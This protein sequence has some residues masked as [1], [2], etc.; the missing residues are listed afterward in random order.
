MND[1]P[2][3]PIMRWLT[4]AARL[5]VGAVFVVSGCTKM[6]DLW[7]F[8]F[9]IADYLAVWHMDV[10]Q[11]LVLTGAALL[12]LA[13]FTSGTALMLGCYRRLSLLVV[14]AIMGVMLPLTVY[15]AIAS[16]VADCGCFGD[17]LVISNT[18]TLLKNVVI[19]GML[20]IL[21]I[22]NARVRPF[23]NPSLQWISASVSMIY[24]IVVGITGYTIQPLVDFR[25]Y[26][27]GTVLANDDYYDTTGDMV[28]IYE[29]DGARKE[30]TADNLPDDSWTFVDRVESNNDNS[31]TASFTVYDADGDRYTP[32][33]L[34]SADERMLLVLIPD[35]SATDPSMTFTINELHDAIEA[36]GG[37][38]AA[39]IGGSGDKIIKRWRDF[40]LADY[41][42]YT[43]D[44]TDI[45]IMA[46][47][48]VALVMTDNDRIVWKRTISSIDPDRITTDNPDSLLLEELQVYTDTSPRD[49]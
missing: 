1:R 18:A 46:R 14:S 49:I 8:I 24:M 28:F 45:K 4:L 40:S 32:G 17:W 12:S 7:G 20:V 35:I 3:S 23:I 48:T 19:T 37:S 44:P 42:V 6:I 2:L 31:D 13:E 11:P 36:A 25:P 26:P 5:I 21:W 10:P 27:V 39:I 22:G 29:K 38:M 43:A 33:D 30:F 9:K 41:P 16:P 34:V 47:G 15:I